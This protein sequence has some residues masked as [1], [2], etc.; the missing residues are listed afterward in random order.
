MLEP[1]GIRRQEVG[2][3]R[4][5]LVA[6]HTAHKL[7]ILVHSPA[8]YRRLGQLAAHAKEQPLCTVLDDYDGTSS[9]TSTIA[10]SATMTRWSRPGGGFSERPNLEQCKNLKRHGDRAET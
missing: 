5:G 1:S 3:T 8:A 7:T 6:F 9:L 4:G 10:R 2:L